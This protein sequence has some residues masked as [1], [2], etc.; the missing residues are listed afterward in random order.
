MKKLEKLQKGDKVAIL[1]PSFAAP[2]IFPHIYELGLDR[3]SN[4]FGLIPVEYP[5]TKELNAS[6]EDK[7]RDLIS[8]FEDDEIKAVIAT[9][10]GD[11][12]VTYVKNLPKDIFVNNPKL[13]FGYSDNTHLCNF[14]FLNGIPSF[15]GSCLMTQFAMQKEMDS[16][17]KKYINN[18][19]FSDVKVEL[20]ESSEFNEISLDWGDKTL[21]NTK[22]KYEKNPGWKWDG[23]E[24]A[25][26]VIWGGCL[27]S[28]DDILRNNIEI[29]SLDDFKKI[30]LILESSE[31]MPPTH[32]VKRVLRAMG[33]R[34]IISN[35]KGVLVG[36]AKAWTFGEDEDVERRDD[37]R[38]QQIETVLE[39]VRKYNV[40][41][42]VIQNLDFGH[43][44]PQVPM[45]Y[46]GKIEI[47]SKNKKIFLEF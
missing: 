12:Q 40:N 27:E 22:R 11:D 6:V 4:E 33:E 14:L 36:R 32:Y 38:N 19:L 28:V 5:T 26:G 9:I 2:A 35:I 8:A 7:T 39:T 41:I 45:P 44:D 15:Y 42:P 30:V 20:N 17:T 21:L 29:P 25:E 3:I 18:A 31:E 13:F 37:Y 34:G 23:G 24:N 46:G 43:T 10:G 47:D 1:S 16:Y